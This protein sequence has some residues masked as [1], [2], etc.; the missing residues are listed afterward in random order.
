[1]T[2]DTRALLKLLG[3]CLA[4]PDAET[5]A[6]LPEIRAAA[7]GLADAREREVLAGFLDRVEVEPELKLQEHYTAAFDMNPS[8][9]LN[10]TWH[11]MGDREDRG[12]ALAD[13]LAVYLQAGF[14]PAV[15]ELPDFLP[16]MLEF[17]AAAALEE[18]HALIRRCLATVPAIAA[19]LKES[20]SPY[21]VPLEMVGEIFPAA[22][23]EVPTRETTLEIR[24]P[25]HETRNK[26]ECSKGQ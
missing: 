19:R 24:N 25:K 7:A 14:E 9:S 8:A 5:L 23:D 16:L 13:L 21:A 4:Y 3:L 17:L 10:L 1:M 15:G 6:A 12:R 26:S 20:G 22:T 2:D 18:P 11:L